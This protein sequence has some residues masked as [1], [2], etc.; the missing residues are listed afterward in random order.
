MATE[1]CKCKMT[2]IFRAD[3][4]DYSRQMGEDELGKIETLKKTLRSDF[5]QLI[6][7]KDV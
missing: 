2:A 7:F 1:G 5:H 3:L 4:V 6:G